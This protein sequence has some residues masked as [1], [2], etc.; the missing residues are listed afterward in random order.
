MLLEQFLNGAKQFTLSQEQ[1]Q[2]DEQDRQSFVDTF[3]LE[4]LKTMV[5]SKYVK[6]G[7]RD[8]FSYWLEF[9][10]ILTG[11]GGGNA[12]KFYIYQDK[13]GYYVKGVGS[14]KVILTG[15]TLQ[16][17]YS[18]LM[19]KI[20]DAVILAKEDKVD[21]IINLGVPIWNMVLIKILMIYC[22][23]KFFGVVSDNWLVPLAESLGLEKYTTVNSKNVVSLNYHIFKELQQ[24]QET[25]HKNYTE[26]GW[27]VTEF[28]KPKTISYWVA[29]CPDD[30]I[31]EIPK[32]F[33]E[34][35][36]FAIKYDT[37][38]ISDYISDFTH[39]QITLGKYL[40]Q[41]QMGENVREAFMCFAELRKG[42]I[43]AL[44]TSYTKKEDK[45]S[46]P[47]LKVVAQGE[48]L[49]DC[50]HGYKIHEGIFHTIPVKWFHTQPIEHEGLGG[51]RRILQKVKSKDVLD[52]IF[53]K[54]DD[55][56]VVTEDTVTYEQKPSDVEPAENVIMYGPP[57]TGKTY[58]TINKVLETI[59]HKAYKD[60]IKDRE[61]AVSKFNEL[62]SREQ[63]AFCTFHQTY[64]YEDFVEG[65]KSDGEG[66]FIPQDSV[67]KQMAFNAAF[68]A[69]LK[70]PE[71]P[72]GLSN[73]EKA[74]LKKKEVLKNLH[75][76]SAF[77]FDIAD[78][79][80]IVIDEIN[81]GNISKIFGELITL[82][83]SD[84]RLGAENQLIITLPYTKEKFTV[85]Q[86]LCVI[87]TMN[88]AD[89]SIALMDYALRRRFTFEEI[90]PQ[91]ELLEPVEKIDLNRML[92][93][94][95]QRIE[96][97]YD[98]DHTIGHAYFM[99]SKTAHDIAK[100]LKNKII[101]LLQEY[102]YDD[103]EKIGLILGGIGKSEQDNHIIYK[104]EIKA[105]D[106]FRMANVDTDYGSKTKYLIKENIGLKEMSN[107]YEE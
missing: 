44:K 27:Y 85:P 18:M 61:K 74:Q 7:S 50:S 96:Y 56:P 32:T 16:K 64:G 21:E 15:E 79:Y 60:I 62:I 23:D 70:K 54:E 38:D 5:I 81:R 19:G 35:N 31:Q 53:T 95:N 76:K 63:V 37:E 98:R 17:E 51:Y 101:P 107:I 29:D 28:S 26:L 24:Y 30:E 75:D 65:L 67:F 3:P 10:G 48:I 94:I 4:S 84:K 36:M 43:I 83:E 91:P 77:N 14:K 87:G 69:L 20:Y 82:L 72:L 9:K 11:I 39:D 46:V 103:W 93:K 42:D 68:S 12:S 106:I 59:D 71:I 25:K 8:T 41:K 34:E 102:F 80:V 58:N 2:K 40:K 73:E 49:Q 66:N 92:E 13:N 105:N 104:R 6:S 22:P 47:V 100:V 57:G 45:Q 55:S 78:N 88:T 33:I 90:M 99:Y 52:K 89:R 97:L 1:K 86:N